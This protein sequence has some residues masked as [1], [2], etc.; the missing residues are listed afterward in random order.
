MV[1][2]CYIIFNRF[3]D[4]SPNVLFLPYSS[5]F[6]HSSCLLKDFD[7]QNGFN[8]LVRKM[9]YEAERKAGISRSPIPGII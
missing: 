1:I 8:V 5:N 6:Q 9:I 2:F 3:S 7:V 4:S